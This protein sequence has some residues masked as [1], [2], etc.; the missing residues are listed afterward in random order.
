VIY[1]PN[2]S[3]KSTLRTALMAA[4]F[5]N[6]TSQSEVVE[7]WTSW[8]QPERCEIKLEYWNQL[9]AL[10]QLR[11]DFVEH[12]VALMAGE[13]WF[14]TPKTIQQQITED[15]GIPSED[16]YMLCA[17]LDSKTLADLGTVRK[18]IGKM[19]AGLMT[20]AESGSDVLQAIKRLDEAMKELNKGL[21]SPSKIPGPLKEVKDRLPLLAAERRKVET[22]LA[23]RREREQACEQLN[24]TLLKAEQRLKDLDYILLANRKLQETQKR[25]ETLIQQDQ[26]YEQLQQQR[27]RLGQELETL[28]ARVSGDSV[29]ALSPEELEQIRELL[30]QEAQLQV[31]AEAKI[32]IKSKP[33]WWYWLAGIN[34]AVAGLILILKWPG[35]G[36]LTLA[37]GTLVLGLGWQQRRKRSADQKMLEVK[38]GERRQK[39]ERMAQKRKLWNQLVGGNLEEVLKKWP[40]SQQVLAQKNALERRWQESE[41]LDEEQWKVVRRELRLL[42]DTLED[43]ALAGVILAPL[44]MARQE[45]ERQTLSVQIEE[46]R[47]QRDKFQTLL[48]H[49]PAHYDRLVELDERIA[50]AKE[51]QG[52]LEQQA[53]IG[54]LAWDGLERAR[55]ATLHPARQILE[56]EAGRLLGLISGGRYT[57]VSVDDEDLACQ[58]LIPETNRWDDPSVLSHGTFDQFYLSLR[59]ALGD[60]LAG[61]K[62]PPLLLDDPFTTFDQERRERFLEWLKIRSAEQQILFFTCRKDYHKFAD[63]VIDLEAMQVSAAVKGPR[64]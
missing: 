25:R 23:S 14:K 15:L 6:P 38:F 41:A 8:G 4:L 20:G 27:E 64:R 56:T 12:K 59:V 7:R 51:R 42:Q 35:L 55:K 36:G 58:V 37:L 44:E 33:L 29:A 10:C 39:A 48:E 18:Q 60:I 45:R 17:S 13:E 31:E 57:Q 34:L 26:R 54:Q 24:Q 61:G 19:L 3:G 28:K 1:G 11:K 30:A 9:G 62:K 52:Y 49:D 53:R 47:R 21:L 63:R 2:E 43:P 46:N 5:G 50:E 40:E 16:F 22:D 32:E